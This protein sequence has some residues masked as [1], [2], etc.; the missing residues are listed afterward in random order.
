[1]AGDGKRINIPKE[2][3]EWYMSNNF[4][5]AQIAKAEYCAEV[6]IQRYMKAYGLTKERKNELIWHKI[7]ELRAKGLHNKIIS[8]K[9]GICERQIYWRAK[10]HAPNCG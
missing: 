5:R 10:N 6:T 9:L 7:M 2:K 3:L 1:V 4:T 8:R